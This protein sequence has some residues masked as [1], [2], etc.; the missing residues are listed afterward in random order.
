MST[1]FAGLGACGSQSAGEQ[2]AQ[3]PFSAQIARWGHRLQSLGGLWGDLGTVLLGTS[4]LP[5]LGSVASSGN[6]NQ[7]H[8]PGLLRGV[9]EM[10]ECEKPPVA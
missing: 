8:Q 2:E 4:H 5:S 6:W 10:R 9:N 1:C 7:H 3:H